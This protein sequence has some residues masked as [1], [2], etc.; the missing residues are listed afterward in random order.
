VCRS[1][2]AVRTLRGLNPIHI[3]VV[4]VCV[5]WIP[6]TV[7]IERQSHTGEMPSGAPVVRKRRH[8]RLLLIARAIIEETLKM[9][10]AGL[11]K[12]E[13]VGLHQAGTVVLLRPGPGAIPRIGHTTGREDA[14]SI[15]AEAAPRLVQHPRSRNDRRLDQ[16]VRNIGK[17]WTI[18]DCGCGREQGGGG[19]GA[20]KSEFHAGFPPVWQW[21]RPQRA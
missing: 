11:Y 2:G 1:I 14:G 17:T 8:H 13:I 16:A 19:R 6:R 20:K 15:V 21:Y 5:A 3:D 9:G 18:G 10:T 12:R 7:R 4:V